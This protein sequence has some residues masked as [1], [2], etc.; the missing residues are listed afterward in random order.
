MS[1]L[2]CGIDVRTILLVRGKEIMARSVHGSAV[3]MALQ[4]GL[5]Y[6][7]VSDIYHTSDL[8]IGDHP[9]RTPTCPL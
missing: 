6:E 4:M 8:L 5:Q 9:R 1:L 2:A 7:S 3:A